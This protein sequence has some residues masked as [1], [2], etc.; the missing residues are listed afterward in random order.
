M[1][2]IRKKELEELSKPLAHDH[3]FTNQHVR[4]ISF[5][6]KRARKVGSQTEL[7]TDDDED[8]NE[9]EEGLKQMLKNAS[10][11]I[12]TLSKKLD[13]IEFKFGVK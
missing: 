4:R 6:K 9:S 7:E 13:R 2:Q 5:K 3:S 8:T 1:E 11:E 12:Q 10:P